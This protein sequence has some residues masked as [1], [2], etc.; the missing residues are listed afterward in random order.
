M[1]EV[2]VLLE[3]YAKKLDNGWVA[4]STVCLITTKDKKIISDPG[5]HREKLLDA[6][7]NEGLSTGSIDF[8]FL[9]HCHSD[10]ILLAGIFENAKFITYDTNL[11]Y[12]KDT[13]IEFDR[14]ELGDEIE[15]LETPGHVLEHLS[16]LVQT[17]LGKVAIVGDVIFWTEGEEQVFDMGQKDQAEAKGM[18]METLVE[19]RKKIVEVADYIVPGHGKMFRVEK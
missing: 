6:L 16:L 15:I 18:N 17:D 12:N 14:H 7:K 3:G 11:M 10:H 9:S 1:A 8:V 4:N 19:S 2:K 13:L 5:C